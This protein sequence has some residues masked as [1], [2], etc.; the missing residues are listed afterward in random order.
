MISVGRICCRN[1]RTRRPRVVLRAPMTSPLNAATVTSTGG[2]SGALTLIEGATFCLSDTAGDITAHSALGLFAH[3]ARV[4]SVC[5][6]RLDGH[7]CEM[8]A[9]R[10]ISA[11]EAEFVL[12]RPPAPGSADSSL[13]LVRRRTMVPAGMVETIS[14]HNLSPEDTDA[15]LTIDCNAD[16]TD[17]FAVKA[18]HAVEDRAPAEVRPDALVLRSESEPGRWVRIR[19]TA[20]PSIEAPGLRFELR[21]PARTTWTTTIEVLAHAPDA[22]SADNGD[23]AAVDATPPGF[24]VD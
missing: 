15:R 9:L 12:R 10:E 5:E 11:R 19:A 7:R 22:E 17:L 24:A 20:E 16:F 18:G 23:A 8:L 6:L 4:V 21:V 13:L 14:L 3:D 2:G 1:A